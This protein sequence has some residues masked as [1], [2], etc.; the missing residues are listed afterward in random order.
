MIILD[1]SNI[2][3]RFKEDRIELN[4]FWG[5][6]ILTVNNVDKRKDAGTY[7]CIVC[8][9]NNTYTANLNVDKIIGEHPILGLNKV[10]LYKFH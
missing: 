3:I 4:N 1:L 6:S 9:G 8:R 2:T 5:Y 7:K 10:C